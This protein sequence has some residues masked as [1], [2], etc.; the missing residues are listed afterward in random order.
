M[1]PAI[2]LSNRVAG[3]ARWALVALAAA[4]LLGACAPLVVGGAMVGGALMV[5]DRRT[6]GAQVEDQAIELKAANRVREAV[7]DRGH[8][9]ITSYNRAVLITGEAATEADR[10]A[11]EQAVGKVEN[12]RSV[13]N[14][15]AVMGSSSL[16]SRSSDTFISG[17]VKAAFVDAKDMHANAFKVVTER[18]VVYLM[19][20]VTEREATRATDIARGIPGVLKVVRVFEI[21]TEAELADLQR[22]TEPAK[23]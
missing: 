4:T 20:R 15:T 11:V 17:R 12:L 5:T 3:P 21:L 16:T 13:L 7:G 18:G 22:K 10:T 1:T 8:F 6:S 19:G 14:E 9:N 2:H 23:K